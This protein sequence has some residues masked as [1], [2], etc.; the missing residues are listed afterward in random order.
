MSQITTDA[1][2]KADAVSKSDTPGR[3]A[4]SKL[5]REACGRRPG[6][7][8]GEASQ[9]PIYKNARRSVAPPISTG[10]EF[11]RLSQMN[12][13]ASGPIQAVGV[14]GHLL[15]TQPKRR[16][17]AGITEKAK[18]A[19]VDTAAGNGVVLAAPAAVSAPRCGASGSFKTPASVES[20]VP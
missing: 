5:V 11:E 1:W 18:L 14:S 6:P 8:L 2:V 17:G 16:V 15:S 4:S 7:D 19:W 3:R 13:D 12:D 20:G 9:L 10:P